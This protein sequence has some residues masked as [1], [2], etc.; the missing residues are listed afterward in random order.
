[1]KYHDLNFS[2]E[3]TRVEQVWVDDESLIWFV[4]YSE[5]SYDEH[6]LLFP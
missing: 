5:V 2:I 1:M 3:V 4:Q 6:G